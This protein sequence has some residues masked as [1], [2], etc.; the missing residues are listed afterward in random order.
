MDQ[1]TEFSPPYLVPHSQETIRI[2][3]KDPHLLIL[4]KPTLL[5][6]VPGRHRL[7][8]DCLIN[9]LAAHYPGVSAV[10]RLDLDT[11][12]VIIVP[13]TRIALSGLARQFQ[14]RRIDK[15]YHAMVAGRILKGEGEITLPLKKDWTNRP[16]QK[17]CFKTGKPSLTRWRVIDH[18]QNSTLVELKPVTG[19]SHQLRVH[20][21][22]I[23]H[24]ILGCDLYAPKS[25]FL[26]A[27][28]LLL[29]ASRI[30]FRH[31]I[32]LSKLSAN[33][34]PHFLTNLTTSAA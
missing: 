26:A 30:T 23:G 20:L 14:E 22:E 21:L 24:P 11:S 19:R 13:R 28:R 29:H 1:S 32:Y 9:R 25:V 4:E 31:P 27:P 17:V 18:Y 5:L 16:R 7:N 12:G 8:H 34:P 10:H 33:V 15:T 3:Y 2:L 6:T